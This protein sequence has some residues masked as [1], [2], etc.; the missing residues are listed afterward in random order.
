MMRNKRKDQHFSK[1]YN[2]FRQSPSA[3]LNWLFLLCFASES[4]ICV[5]TSFPRNQTVF[6]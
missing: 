1:K 4:I 5:P 2:P 3:L 6:E